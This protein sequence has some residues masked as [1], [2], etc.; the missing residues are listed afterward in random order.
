[1]FGS[2]LIA[3]SAERSFERSQRVEPA[4]C[5]RPRSRSRR[6]G[7]IHWLAQE[8]AIWKSA[9]QNENEFGAAGAS[10]CSWRTA[11][12]LLW[13][14]ML[15]P[16]FALVFVLL[17]TVVQGAPADAEF[18]GGGGAVALMALECVE[19]RAPFKVRDRLYGR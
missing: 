6:A 4:R 5:G 17:Q 15:V 10:V 9:E 3:A 16:A 2:W 14:W 18:S 8:R 12:T 7:S 1:M 11:G 13:T 19:N